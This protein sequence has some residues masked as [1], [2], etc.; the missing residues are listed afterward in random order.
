M[1]TLRLRP[2]TDAS[3]TSLRKGRDVRP[4]RA[5][6]TATPQHRV[7]QCA[8]SPPKVDKG[9]AASILDA[10][11][12]G[13]ASIQRFA[14][15]PPPGFPSG[16]AGDVAL[17]LLRDPLAF[18][19]STQRRFGDI[20][21]LSLGGQRVVLVTDPSAAKAVLI[22]NPEIY[23]KFGTAFFPGSSLAGNGLLVSDGDIWRRQRQL[24]TP[25]FRRAAVE[26]YGASMVDCTASTLRGKR[27]R[28]G[29]VR[30][31][32]TDFN[33]LTLRITLTALF[34]ADMD[35]SAAREVTGM[36]ICGFLSSIFL[37]LW[38][39]LKVFVRFRLYISL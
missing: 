19:A 37:C 18:L 22:D 2:F 38:Y 36:H 17:D 29:A 26:R 33:E 31:V 23:V 14:M 13:A 25:A 8:S 5:P 32:Y 7:V 10:L 28:E 1:N 34:G 39:L 11:S 20:V 6:R 3:I 12:Q 21:G 30:D 15:P 4:L 35:S 9:A 24:A 27:W 16:P